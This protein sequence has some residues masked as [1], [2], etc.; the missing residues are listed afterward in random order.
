MEEIVRKP[1]FQCNFFIVVHLGFLKIVKSV[2]KN[3]VVTDEEVFLYNQDAI[4]HLLRVGVQL[5]QF[6]DDNN[7][8]KINFNEIIKS[9]PPTTVSVQSGPQQLINIHIGDS[10]KPTKGIH[11]DNVEDCLSFLVA[12]L[13]ASLFSL[14]ASR[15]HY[16]LFRKMCLYLHE[17]ESGEKFYLFSKWED[18]STRTENLKTVV[19]NK[20]FQKNEESLMTTFDMFVWLNKDFAQQYYNLLEEILEQNK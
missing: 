4:S 14:N 10:T 8:A 3:C 20:L 6:V 19:L 16:T 13:E 18:Y 5:T 2:V 15:H 17:I 9:A 11:I 12:I 7:T 1:L